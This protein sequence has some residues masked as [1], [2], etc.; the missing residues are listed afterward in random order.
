MANQEHLEVLKQGW[1]VWNRWRGDNTNLQPDLSGAD[2][3]RASL[4]WTDFWGAN[5]SQAVFC[6]AS[7][8]RA[9]L[10]GADLRE[11]LLGGAFLHEADLGEADLSGANLRSAD[12]CQA[13][14]GGANLSGADLI[15][16]GLSDAFLGRA[17]LGGA[18]LRGVYI[19][20]AN[21]NKATLD[22][23]VLRV[24]RVCPRC[25]RVNLSVIL[26]CTYCR[27]W[28]RRLTPGPLRAGASIK[29]ALDFEIGRSKEDHPVVNVTWHDAVAYC[30]W[31]AGVTGKAYRLPS[32]AEWE[33]AARG[34]DGRIY[35]WGD[36][37][38]RMRCNASG[39]K[40]GGTTRVGNYSPLGDSP[41][42]CADMV[43]NVCEWTRSL[44]RVYP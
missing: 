11:A 12:L 24:L 9:T 17:D 13:F 44:Y 8:S 21:L 23:R 14:L 30:K 6:G 28:L 32:E 39:G 40:R 33:K 29:K 42:G 41:Y 15:R 25:G 20:E 2:L 19:S 10:Q 4:G 22:T 35:P 38:H 5:L 43:G 3:S 18:E 34:T 7:L 37:W 27:K 31:L 1:D 16:A 36:E 26:R